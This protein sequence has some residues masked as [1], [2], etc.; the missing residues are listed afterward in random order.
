LFGFARERRSNK[1][2]YDTDRAVPAASLAA[3]TTAGGAQTKASSERE[4]VARLRDLTF[5]AALVEIGTPRTMMESARLVRIGRAE[6][7][8]N[9]DG[10][11]VTGAMPELLHRAGLLTREALADPSSQVFASSREMYRANTGS[12]MAHIW[13]TTPAND[14]HAQLAAGRDWLRANLAATAAGLAVHP[15]SQALQEFPEMAGCYQEAHALLAPDGGRVQMLGRIGYA[16]A[17][18]PAPRWPVET[19]LVRT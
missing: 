7:E 11:D 9:P 19:H 5:R 13:I 10:I 14:R 3:L 1:R 17:V 16:P 18:D 6:V 12:A 2:A 15:L 8:A 4:H